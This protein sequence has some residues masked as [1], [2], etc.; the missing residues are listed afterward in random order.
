M[1]KNNNY[2]HR[3]SSSEHASNYKKKGHEDEEVFSSLI[4]GEVIPGQKKVDVIGPKGTRY[5]CKGGRTHWQILLYRPSNFIN[6]DWGELGVLFEECLNCFPVDYSRYDQDKINAKESIYSYLREKSGEEIHNHEDAKGLDF[7]IKKNL[8]NSLRNNPSLLKDIMGLD[9]TYLN[10]KLK[11]QVVT[12]KMKEK[13]EEEHQ[14]R[15][16]LEKGMFANEDVDKLVIKERANFLVFDK[17]DVLDIFDENLKAENSV[18]GYGID[19]I[20]LDGQKTIIKYKTNIIELEIR[21]DSKHYR[22][23]RFN[24]KRKKALD[25]LRENATLDAERYKNV[26]FYKKI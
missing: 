8:R 16:F 5:S 9:N 17:S 25:L 2:S 24:M 3:G 4:K 23:V 12:R 20:N 13:F 6:N 22:E 19:D 21:N 10:A 26:L 11:L 7:K 1:P 15:G 18:A 14:I